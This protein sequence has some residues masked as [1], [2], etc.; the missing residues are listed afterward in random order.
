MNFHMQLAKEWNHKLWVTVPNANSLMLR[1]FVIGCDWMMAPLVFVHS[2]LQLDTVDVMVRL[3]P[4]AQTQHLLIRGETKAY[5]LWCLASCLACWCNSPGQG[6]TACLYLPR[7]WNRQF[8]THCL[9]LSKIFTV[10][11]MKHCNAEYPTPSLT[12]WKIIHKSDYMYIQAQMLS[13]S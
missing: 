4:T 10:I 12:Y 1:S 11:I 6:E 5:Q 2:V 7:K 13:Y 8:S 3:Y 9:S